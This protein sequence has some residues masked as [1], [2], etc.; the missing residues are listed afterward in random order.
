MENGR[1]KQKY[2]MQNENQLIYTSD[3]NRNQNDC[4][5]AVHSY[6]SCQDLRSMQ[7]DIQKMGKKNP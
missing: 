7:Q 5:E 3:E 2:F 4:A 6:R 1:M